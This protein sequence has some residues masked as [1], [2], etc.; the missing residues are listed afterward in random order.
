ME[1]HVI[2]AA[3][4]F[5][6]ERGFSILSTFSDSL[7]SVNLLNYGSVNVGMKL[8][9]VVDQILFCSISLDVKFNYI[10]IYI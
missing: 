7:S 3:I 2:E 9:H 5:F 1:L 6:G 10:Y 8:W 4:S